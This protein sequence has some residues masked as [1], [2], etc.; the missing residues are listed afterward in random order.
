MIVSSWFSGNRHVLAKTPSGISASCRGFLQRCT[1]TQMLLGRLMYAGC[2]PSLC[3][4]FSL[5]RIACLLLSNERE[6]S[7]LQ[8]W[9]PYM[10][11]IQQ[12]GSFSLNRCKQAARTNEKEPRKEG[13]QP[14]YIQADL[15]DAESLLRLII[16][17]EDSQI[18]QE[19]RARSNQQFW[20]DHRP[21]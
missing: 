18:S 14:V 19:T 9:C 17:K 12:D 3:G 8:C 1:V 2:R 6:P 20:A 7:W 15:V 21:L 13:R 10:D 11:R 5:V 4:L 16:G